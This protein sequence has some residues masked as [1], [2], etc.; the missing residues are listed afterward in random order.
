MRSDA[1]PRLDVSISPTGIEAWTG[2]HA[3]SP[4]ADSVPVT[5][6][7]TSGLATDHLFQILDDDTAE[8]VDVGNDG[9]VG[10]N[11]ESDDDAHVVIRGNE[12]GTYP[13]L[14]GWYK[15]DTI[16]PA[17][18]SGSFIL[19][20]TDSSG[21]GNHLTGHGETNAESQ[22]ATFSPFLSAASAGNNNNT[23]L[24]MVDM[25]GTSAAGGR[26]G[27]FTID[28][29]T[30]SL[31]VTTGWTVFLLV[32]DYA[33]DAHDHSFFGCNT[34][35]GDPRT[36]D[37]LR[38]GVT[39]GGVTQVQWS[40][41]EGASLKHF[42]LQ[43][44]HT[45]GSDT[46]VV[47]LR[48]EASTGQLR[49]WIDGN[50]ITADNTGNGTRLTS[51][52]FRYL[53]KHWV[54]SGDVV[55]VEKK[56]LYEVALFNAALT[57]LEVASLGTYGAQRLA[58]S[59]P[60]FPFDPGAPSLDLTRWK[61]PDGTTLSRIDE[62]GRF[63]FGVTDPEVPVHIV[64]SSGQQLRIGTSTT[65]YTGFI[66]AAGA[67]I[68]YTLPST[69]TI[70]GVLHNSA[71]SSNASSWSWS[72]VSLT[73]DVS[74][75]LPLSNLAQTTGPSV[76]GRSANTLGD[77]APILG[78][79][80]EVMAINA[81]G[82]V[83]DF[84]S[85]SA[86][87]IVS[88]PLSTTTLN[89]VPKFTNTSGLTGNSGI[90]DDGTTIT[91]A[92]HVEI[93]GVHKLTL[94]ITAAATQGVI[95]KGSAPILHDFGT[96]TY[97]NLFIGK[98][99]G[100]LT[101]SG[102]DQGNYSLGEE[103]LQGLTD[104]AG[105]FAGGYRA[106]RAV[107]TGDYNFGLG[108]GSLVATTT[109]TGN[110]G[111]GSFSGGANLSGSNNVYIGT[112][113]GCTTNALSNSVAIG[114]LAKVDASN[115]VIIGNTDTEVSGTGTRVV[116]IRG[117][118]GIRNYTSGLSALLATT[119]IASTSKTFTFPNKS[120]VIAV[121][122]VDLAAEVTG[123]LPVTNLNS[124]TGAS[125]TTYWQ[126][127]GT[128]GTPAGTGVTG[129]GTYRTLPMWDVTG[130]A[131]EDSYISY[132]AS[133]DFLVVTKN[134]ASAGGGGGPYDLTGWNDIQVSTVNGQTPLYTGD[135]GSFVQA[136]DADLDSWAAITRASGFDTFVATP[137]SAN[138]KAL[139]TDELGSASGKVIF[140]EGTLAITAAK[141]L[142]A[143]NTLTLSGTDSTV[144]TFP[145]TTAT[146]ARTDAAQTF[147]GVQTFSAQDVHTL[148]IDLS[149]S[150]VVNSAVA[151]APA[152]SSFTFQPTV[153]Q[154][155]GTLNGTDRYLYKFL[156]QAGAAKLAM[157]ANG[158]VEFNGANASNTGFVQIAGTIP[159]GPYLGINFAPTTFTTSG[160]IGPF[161]AARGGALFEVTIPGSEAVS[162]VAGL[163]SVNS[164]TSGAVPN[165]WAGAFQ[166]IRAG[167]NTLTRM[168]G[169]YLRDNSTQS[170]GVL[171]NWSAIYGATIGTLP[172][173]THRSWIE[174]AD[175][176]TAS[177]TGSQNSIL[178]SQTTSTYKALAFRDQDAWI[179][180]KD[181]AHL[182]L[183]AT[184][185]VD[186]NI[187]TTEQFAV[188]S[189]LATF[190]DS[191][192]MAFNTGTGTKIGT[193]TTQK[194]GFWN[195]APVA[196]Y[197]TTGTLTGFTAGTTTPVLDG[198]TFTGNT[199]ATAY[200]IGDIVRALKLA[201]I[202][203][204]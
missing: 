106:L 37:R 162:G 105:N 11:V 107:T 58:G 13:S 168:G 183:N 42:S 158:Q 203:A 55:G 124:G 28:T 199:G 108:E 159:A 184:T 110:V 79:A 197:A 47:V 25:N 30:F 166:T 119:S 82:T 83:A 68:V 74:G 69:N 111:V 59:S 90:S 73:A 94:P 202:M 128:W 96:S 185:S 86:A 17:Q 171:T 92:E 175:L 9:H 182:D 80:S 155:T 176:T 178:L 134:L 87:G 29:G 198:S 148:G 43:Y 40:I 76:L 179:N 191:F 140:A 91:M 192:N 188:T 7:K 113:S 167:N 22:D 27:Y 112:S 70:A 169:I 144:M 66:D 189:S 67:G 149:T 201:G 56:G 120:G 15:A 23:F 95:F 121:V 64:K 114:A 45:S 34:N 137:T 138:F 26:H 81:A 18:L 5:I 100:N 32:R 19:A 173:A 77:Y 145:T 48:C 20:W 41:A 14:I 133:G 116:E 12:A 160:T 142:T 109:G 135:I 163:F 3:W 24:P 99:A 204:A 117:E 44:P 10:F 115:K 123:N 127:D 139:V 174:L 194:I 35:L 98:N 4:S 62:N 97:A 50:I 38:M 132:N 193:G 85:L 141:T 2:T 154:G 1:A 195:V 152:A 46:E 129:S 52:I 63:G 104:G 118:V 6:N 170:K 93:T 39:S 146:I 130:A 8:F 101:L 172:L 122:P 72:L 165:A 181:A 60:T 88:F 151:D 31:S 89:A 61:H 186:V 49:C 126:G 190:A 156:N 57:D 187:G 36:T 51:A 84:I 157:F 33:T 71:P 177:V 75:D 16:V 180:S 161:T 196:Q 147:T 150:G 136:W 164:A 125:A 65:N 131:L 21:S 153:A 200:T 53:G 54:G 102:G 103:A 78:T 143:T